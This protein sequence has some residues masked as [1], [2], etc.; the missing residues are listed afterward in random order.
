MRQKK[1]EVIPLQFLLPFLNIWYHLSD[2]KDFRGY[3][4]VQPIN[5]IDRKCMN[6][7]HVFSFVTDWKYAQI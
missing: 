4:K 6:H 7:N 5:F 3:L 2:L 1:L